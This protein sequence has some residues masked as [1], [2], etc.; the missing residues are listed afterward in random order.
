MPEVSYLSYILRTRGEVGDSP[1]LEFLIYKGLFLKKKYFFLF[2]PPYLRNS[3]FT[4]KKE[5]IES[6]L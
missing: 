3:I 4:S 1:P 2:L 6:P 5:E